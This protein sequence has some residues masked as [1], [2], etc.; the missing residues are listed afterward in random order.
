M[1]ALTEAIRNN[2]SH[3][4]NK[5]K[6]TSKYTGNFVDRKPSDRPIV[7]KDGKLRHPFYAKEFGIAKSLPPA[8]K[9]FGAFI[10]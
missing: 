8:L 1:T 4:V 5:P 6:Y 3:D 9:A 7:C 10:L 2:F